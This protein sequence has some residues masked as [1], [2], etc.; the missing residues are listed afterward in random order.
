MESL[1][2]RVGEIAQRLHDATRRALLLAAEEW[3][4][5]VAKPAT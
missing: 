5:G 4:K 2:D 1:L 3:S